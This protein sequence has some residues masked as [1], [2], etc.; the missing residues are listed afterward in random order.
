[1]GVKTGAALAGAGKGA[2]TG[3][4]I[5]SVVPGIGTAVGAGVGA[6]AGAIGGFF[7]GK[8]QEKKAKEDRRALTEGMNLNQK[9]GEDKRLARLKAAQSILGSAGGDYALDPGLVAQLGI[10]RKYDFSKAV[11]DQLAGAGSAYA[12]GLFDDALAYGDQFAANKIDTMG[13]GGFNPWDLITSKSRAGGDSGFMPSPVA[14]GNTSMENFDPGFDPT[15]KGS[16][17]ALS[18][19]KTITPFDAKFGDPTDGI[20]ARNAYPTGYFSRGR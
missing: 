16:G 20:G 15:R 2:A 3:A 8:G 9:M 13:S 17:I 18:S 5:G 7:K 12:A 19:G 1:M 11:P 14:G 6:L 4:S 10:E